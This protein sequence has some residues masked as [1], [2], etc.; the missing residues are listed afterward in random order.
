MYYFLRKILPCVT[1]SGPATTSSV[2]PQKFSAVGSSDASRGGV[3]DVSS[4]STGAE[5]IIK[6]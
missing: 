2:L 1:E 5:I 4:A 6:Y 3:I